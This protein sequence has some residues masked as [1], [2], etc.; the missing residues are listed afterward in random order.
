VLQIDIADR[1]ILSHPRDLARPYGLF[2]KPDGFQGWTGLANARR[3]E[4]A[5]AVAHGDF[6]VPVFLGSRVVTID[7]WAIGESRADLQ[8]RKDVLAGLLGTGREVTRVTQDQESRWAYSRVV[9]ADPEEAVRRI[10][11]GVVSSFQVQLVLADPRK[12]GDVN[13]FP[14]RG[15]P[16]PVG[17]KGNF[18][19]FPEFTFENP[20][21]SYSITS[22]GG[23]FVVTGAT[24]GGT[25]VVNL[26]NGRVYRDGVEMFD[27]GRGDLWAVP[28]GVPWPHTT[29]AGCMIRIPDTFV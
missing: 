6:D 29:S 28:A 26:R 21:S 16:V 17:H 10:R 7:G 27:V 24:A 2:L 11:R 15:V 22:P 25:H 4:L 5:R 8:H 3:E 18:P 23:T 13:P 14:S 19:A 1:Q 9:L 12:Y 20:P